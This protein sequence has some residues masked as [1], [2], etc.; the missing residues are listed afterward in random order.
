MKKFVKLSAL[1]IAALCASGASFA[2]PTVQSCAAMEVLQSDAQGLS[3]SLECRAGAWKLVYEGAVPAGTEPVNAYYKMTASGPDNAKFTQNRMVRSVV[4]SRLGQ[5]LAREAVL[6]ESGKLALRECKTADC[7]QYRIWSNSALASAVVTVTP[8][9]KRIQDERARLASDLSLAKTEAERRGSEVANLQQAV[10]AGKADQE[11]IAAEL[12]DTTAEL[13]RVFEDLKRTRA[14]LEARNADIARLTAEHQAS[15]GSVA[16]ASTELAAS[17]AELDRLNKAL[18]KAD[19]AVKAREAEVSRLKE[20][21]AQAKAS[22]SKAASDLEVANQE[23]R[24]V[25]GQLASLQAE[26]DKRGAEAE[27]LRAAA[28]QG[29]A[30]SSRIEGELAQASLEVRRLTGELEKARAEIEKKNE[31]I[32]GLQKKAQKLKLAFDLA[33]A[34]LYPVVESTVQEVH[35]SNAGQLKALNAALKQSLQMLD[36]QRMAY[37]YAIADLIA[38]QNGQVAALKK[39]MPTTDF[40]NLVEDLQPPVVRLNKAREQGLHQVLSGSDE[41]ALAASKDANLK[42]LQKALAEALNALD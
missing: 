17:A 18:T 16:K 11:R 29:Q 42:R 25:T 35:D 19:E 26:A 34:S 20:A 39:A 14:D 23:L 32:E 5:A 9:Q 4:P 1:A 36:A 3:Y 31:S 37:D 30:A 15:K 6:L 28:Q 27:S 10:K 7:T 13:K 40:D 12:E 22:G 2:A 8:E 33:A 21:A 41:K 38:R 24:R